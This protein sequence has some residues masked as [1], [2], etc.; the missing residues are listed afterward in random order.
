[1][2]I[3]GKRRRPTGESFGYRIG[4]RGGLGRV[5]ITIANQEEPGAG[6][7]SSRRARNSPMASTDSGGRS[8]IGPGNESGDNGVAEN[9]LAEDHGWMRR[10]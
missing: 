7:V 9:G 2:R 3:A 4:I 10:A 8:G 6:L 5:R 1:M